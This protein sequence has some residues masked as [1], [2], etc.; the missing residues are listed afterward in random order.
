MTVGGRANP[1]FCFVR[2][3]ECHLYAAPRNIRTYSLLGWSCQSSPDLLNF[4]QNAD[5]I[6]SSKSELSWNQ[7][8][9]ADSIQHASQYYLRLKPRPSTIEP[10]HNLLFCQPRLK[11][12]PF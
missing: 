6:Y 2:P 11:K 7:P 5:I 1:V 4:P 10:S 12:V 8:K 3:C 9:P